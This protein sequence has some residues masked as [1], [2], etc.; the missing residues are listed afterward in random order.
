MTTRIRTARAA[1]KTK[2]APT[3]KKPKVWVLGTGGTIA[4]WGAPR[5]V[6]HEYG[7]P[8]HNL[9]VF[10][11]LDRIPEHKDYVQAKAEMMF[12]AGSGSILDEG[13][14]K[15]TKRI[16]QILREEPDTAGFVVTHGTSSMEEMAY[17]LNLTARTD[18]P[19]VVTGCMRPPS[20]MGTDSDNN[21]LGSL[22]LAAS[23]EA[24][25][26]GVTI[27]LN[28]EINAARDVTKTNSYRLETFQTRELG[29][30]GYLDSDLRPFFYRSPTRKHTSQSEFDVLK[31]TKLPQVDIVFGYEGSDGYL[32]RALTQR[33]VDGIVVAGMGPGGV[34]RDMTDALSEARKKGIHICVTT[35]AGAGRVIRGTRHKAE[36]WI[37]GDNLLPVKAR[38]L[39]KLALTKTKDAEKIQQMFEAY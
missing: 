8:G 11:N 23:K 3:H 38:I 1:A 5:T 24:V 27:M 25:G 13:W 14:L 36:G 21:L 33:K 6:F 2:A 35:R 29:F 18:K 4:S 34:G 17:W 20:A 16:H 31:L 15:M 32:V 19:I 26:K 9:D 12:Q 39:L 28:D 7:R 22:I 30:L 10:Q 37:A